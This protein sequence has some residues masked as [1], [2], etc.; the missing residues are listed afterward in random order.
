MARKKPGMGADA[1]AFPM[2]GTPGSVV[3]LLN[4]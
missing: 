4:A 1:F 2:R 3:S